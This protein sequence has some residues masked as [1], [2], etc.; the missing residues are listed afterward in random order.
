MLGVKLTQS[1]LPS[2][3]RLTSAE[4]PCSPVGKPGFR[5]QATSLY[6]TTC[7]LRDLDTLLN[8]SVPQPPEAGKSLHPNPRAAEDE[9]GSYLHT[10][11]SEQCVTPKKLATLFQV[12]CWG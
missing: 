11:C 5:G 10:Q 2:F 9:L 7:Q 12:G 3:H 4:R 6:P 1:Q 8:C